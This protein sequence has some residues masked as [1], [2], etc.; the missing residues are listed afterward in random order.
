M[1]SQNKIETS[2]YSHLTGKG[3][4]TAQRLVIALLILWSTPIGPEQELLP[5]PLQQPSAEKVQGSSLSP[6][7]RSPRSVVPT[8]AGPTLSSE[9]FIR[10]FKI[11]ARQELLD[12]VAAGQPDEKKSLVLSAVIDH[13]GN[14]KTLR[15]VA[16]PDA[17]SPCVR[18]AVLRMN[19]K[20]LTVG[21][22]LHSTVTVQW[23]VDL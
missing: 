15:A 4:K 18:D 10:S 3:K 5:E 7:H 12:C 23:R 9:Q 16:P 17:M 22:P 20:E 19:F 8:K 6:G 21:F 2:L 13:E 14:I 11:K 1:L